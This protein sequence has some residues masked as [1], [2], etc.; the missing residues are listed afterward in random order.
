MSVEYDLCCKDCKE[1][2]W[3]GSE[4]LSGRQFPYLMEG[5]MDKVSEFLW[6]H[7]GHHLVWEMDHLHEDSEKA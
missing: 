7:E 5:L 3:I 6:D 2:V 1:H 4:G